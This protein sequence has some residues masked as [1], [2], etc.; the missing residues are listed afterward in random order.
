MAEVTHAGGESDKPSVGHETSDVNIRAILLFAAGLVVLGVVVQVGL[1][2]MFVYFRERENAANKSPYPLTAE[3]RQRFQETGERT[4]PPP[5]RLEGL[6]PVDPSH[7][8]GR[9][10]P[11]SAEAQVAEQEAWLGSYGTA[12]QGDREVLHIPITRAMKVLEGKLPA[13]A[14]G[15]TDPQLPSDSNSG[16]APQGGTR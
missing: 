8:V 15:P 6:P 13:R 9:L 1:W 11:G 10:R 4:L 7:S 16:R 12:K 3:Q 5:P 2:G 14:E